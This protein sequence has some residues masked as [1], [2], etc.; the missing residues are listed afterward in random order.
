M[1]DL[2]ACPYNFSH[3]IRPERFQYH[4]LKCQ[5]NNPDIILLV[6]PFN[7]C[8]HFRKSDQVEHITNCPDRGIYEIQKYQF[9]KAIPGQHGNLATPSAFGSSIYRDELLDPQNAGRPQ[10]NSQIAVKHAENIRK[11]HER[12]LDIKEKQDTANPWPKT[13]KIQPQNR[14]PTTKK[15]NSEAE[16]NCGTTSGYV[17]CNTSFISGKNDLMP[18]SIKSPLEGRTRSPSPITACKPIPKLYRY[19]QSSRVPRS[20][21]VTPEIPEAINNPWANVQSSTRSPSPLT[22]YKSIPVLHRYGMTSKGAVSTDTLEVKARIEEIEQEVEAKRNPD[23]TADIDSIN[24]KTNKD[25]LENKSPKTEIADQTAN[26]STIKRPVPM[27]LL[28][29]LNHMKL[30]RSSRHI[31]PSSSAASVEIEC[32][33]PK[34]TLRRPKNIKNVKYITPVSVNF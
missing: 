30:N 11:Y 14:G 13:N 2:I 29:K 24:Q 4:L 16:E 17:T 32:E 21:V 18:S 12:M 25:I 15:C 7:A 27:S 22:G 33:M 20:N 3:Q 1:N 19:G 28:E 31:T 9:S 26:T 10:P 8:H 6:C 34:P 23:A 5:A